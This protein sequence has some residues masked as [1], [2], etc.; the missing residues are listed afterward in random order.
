MERVLK[1]KSSQRNIEFQNTERKHADEYN[2]FIH[3]DLEP[4]HDN[5][6]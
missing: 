1:S 5:K 6:D 4:N 2:L 3:K